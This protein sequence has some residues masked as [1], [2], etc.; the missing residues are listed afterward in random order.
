MHL[1]LAERRR[2]FENGYVVICGIFAV[3]MV[4]TNIIGTKLF[5]LFPT[6]MESGFGSFSSYGPV[7]LTTGLITYP[8]T[9]LFT[10]I[11]SEIYGRRRANVMVTIGFLASILMLLVVQISVAVTPADRYWAD[12][13]GQKILS[14]EIIEVSDGSHGGKTLHIDHRQFLSNPSGG[15][16]VAIAIFDGDEF[17]FSS[18]HTIGQTGGTFGQPYRHCEIFLHAGDAKAGNVVVPAVQLMEFMNGEEGVSIKIAGGAHLPVQ[19]VLIDANKTKYFYTRQ[20]NNEWID[21]D[22][23]QPVG[24]SFP[25]P[26]EALAEDFDMSSRPAAIINAMTPV[27]MQAAMT[28]TFASPGILLMASMMAYLL[29]QYL[30]V[31]MYHFWKR[32]TGVKK[33]WLRNNGSTWVSQLVDTITVNGIFLP[34]AFG[35]D[36]T[37]TTNVI[38]CVYLVKL[39]IAAIDTP[40]IYLG[41]YIE[42]RRLG[43]EWEE[44]VPDL[45]SDQAEALV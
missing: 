10:D 33:M 42:K 30:D 44:E 6:W 3:L 1:S 23:M 35:M 21:L 19:G 18:Y 13:A 38:I 27:D 37:A 36:F 32:I 20:N 15:K 9:F 34:I 16:P 40:L 39:V 12:A 26:V 11:C 17:E 14:T 43:Y 7:I 22:L 25:A 29:A 5:A 2:R 41:V 8:L 45:L 28:A 24:A 4:L 31:F